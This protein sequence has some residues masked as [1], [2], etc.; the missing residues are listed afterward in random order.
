MDKK[1]ENILKNFD[2]NTII[3]QNITT[4]ED[5]IILGIALR[6]LSG[7]IFIDIMKI[8]KE[9]DEI[10]ILIAVDQYN[11]WEVNSAYSNNNVMIKSKNLCIPHCLNF[12]RIKK[13]DPN[14]SEWNLKLGLS[15][16]TTSMKYLEGRKVTYKQYKKSIP[17][18]ITI[19]NYNSVE[20]LSVMTHYRN[21]NVAPKYLYNEDFLGYRMF[22]GSNPRLIRNEMGSYMN[23]LVYR[24][25]NKWTSDIAEGNSD[26][27]N[28]DNVYIFYH[29]DDDIIIM[30][31]IIVMMY[32]LIKMSS[33][34]IILV[35]DDDDDD[36]DDDK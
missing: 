16:A 32:M 10:P 24:Y 12:I 36:D 2:I 27:I 5:L 14:Q 28:N 34:I 17:L 22:T 19:P 6:D 26:D 11:T 31:M 33:M 9:Q 25:I 13:N 4:I 7:S 30:I 1:D 29:D 8:L 21:N 35:D 20:Y 18:M 15:I 23:P 3:A